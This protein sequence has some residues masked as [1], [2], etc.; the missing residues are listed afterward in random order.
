M[1]G[2]VVGER[3][4]EKCLV[5]ILHQNEQCS[6]L[7]TKNGDI[8]DQSFLSSFS[9]LLQLTGCSETLFKSLPGFFQIKNW[10]RIFQGEV[11]E[12]W[13]AVFL[14]GSAWIRVCWG[15]RGFAG[16]DGLQAVQAC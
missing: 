11:A 10:T 9:H 7:R 1:V 12:M 6:F 16:V 14:G 3:K 15:W 8:Q 4:F 2:Q 13:L 5:F